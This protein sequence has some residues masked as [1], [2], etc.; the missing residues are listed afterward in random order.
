V[1][2]AEIQ[3]ALNDSIAALEKSAEAEGGETVFDVQISRAQEIVRQYL[4]NLDLSG[5]PPE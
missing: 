3:Q 1:P 5:T 2:R 4:A